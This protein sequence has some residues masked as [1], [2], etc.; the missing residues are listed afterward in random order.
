MD[1]GNSEFVSRSVGEVDA[2]S[3]Q[4]SEYQHMDTDTDPD[5][6]CQSRAGQATSARRNWE[7]PTVKTDRKERG[8]RVLIFRAGVEMKQLLFNKITKA[9]NE[10]SAQAHQQKVSPFSLSAVGLLLRGC[11]DANE[12]ARR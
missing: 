7:I 5:M 9:T 11:Q 4:A 12:N 8:M 1:G 2:R 10:A 3:K 6:T